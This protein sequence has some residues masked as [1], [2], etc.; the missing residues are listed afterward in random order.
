MFLIIRDLKSFDFNVTAVLDMGMAKG[1]LDDNKLDQEDYSVFTVESASE[2][3]DFGL[4]MDELTSIY[5]A[6]SGKAI[7]KFKTK[8]EGAKR[9]FP[10]LDTVATR[11]TDFVLPGKKAKGKKA[12]PGPRKSKGINIA[13]KA[14]VKPVRAGSKQHVLLAALDDGATLDDLVRVLPTWSPSTIK[15]ALYHDVHNLKGYGVSTEL[16]D[17]TPVYILAMPEGMTEVL[18][19]YKKEK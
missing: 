14:E 6:G 15:S 9:V 16:V 7:K 5:T 2:L 11:A 1:I 19:S 12:A 10:Y 3:H 18:V 13:P 4:S 17:G 8:T